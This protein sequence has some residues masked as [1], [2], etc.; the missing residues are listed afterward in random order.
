MDY[1]N[2]TPFILAIGYIIHHRNQQ[3]NANQILLKGMFLREDFCD[4]LNRI[5]YPE[6]L[7]RL[8]L[9]DSKAKEKLEVI[10]EEV[11]PLIRNRQW[12]KATVLLVHLPNT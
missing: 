2:L 4:P 11:E 7:H 9:F 6:Y 5:R 12:L 8:G 3:P 10:Q 1:N